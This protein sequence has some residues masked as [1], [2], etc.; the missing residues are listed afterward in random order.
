MKGNYWNYRILF[1]EKMKLY[2]I[3][4]VHYQNNKPYAYG[5]GIVTL[6]EET[7][8]SIK[9]V[10]KKVKKAFKKPVLS[11]ENFPKKIKKI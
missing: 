4:E 6:N 11:L 1:N 7:K 5:D 9:W 10:L 2:E 3:H 8:K